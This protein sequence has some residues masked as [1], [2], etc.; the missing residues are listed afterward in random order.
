MA[1]LA[2]VAATVAFFALALLLVRLC[3]R[4]IGAA[5]A[6]PEL[7]DVSGSPAEEIAA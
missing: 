6:P 5:D 7:I 2:F 3:E 4:I 1:D